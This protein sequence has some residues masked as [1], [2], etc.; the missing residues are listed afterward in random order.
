[1]T[2]LELHGIE[3][4]FGATAALDGVDLEVGRGEV[5]ALI[6]ENGA[7]KSTLMNVLSGTFPPDGGAMRL[8]GAPYSPSGPAEARR[9]GIAH[10]HQELSL[11]PHLSVAENILMG[12]EP[13]AFGWIRRDELFDRAARLLEEFGRDE[14]DPRSRTGDLPLPDRQIVEICRALAWN[15]RILLMDEPT[16]TLQRGNVERLFRLVRQ[17]R[18]RGIAVIYISH[19]LEEVRE[20]ADRYT[21]LRDGKSVASGDLQSV[22]D[23]DLISLMVGRPMEKALEASAAPREG[24]SEVLLE[25]QDL[26]APPRLRSASFQLHRGEVL[27]IAGLIG[28]GRTELIRAL[29]G[30]ARATAG[31]VR[32]RGEE[33]PLGRNRSSAQIR[34]GFGFLSEDR[35]G[36]GLALQISVADNVTIS[37]LSSCARGGWIDLRRQRR[38]AEEV[39][40]RLRIKAP[41]ARSP[42]LRLSGGNQQKVAL[43]RLLHQDPEI[44]LLDEPARGIDIA[45]KSDI[46]R[47]ITRLAAQGKAVLMVSSYLP[48]LLGVCDRIAVMSRG[49]LSPARPAAEWTPETIL[50]V[51]VG[52]VGEVA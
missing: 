40:G 49:R 26:A 39:M 50:Q 7:G 44:L 15:A 48:E 24:S 3:K 4:R 34:R 8:S 18:D 25:V 21:V 42:V 19:F 51:A 52:G 9:R 16:S 31:R 23:D 28:S 11:C 5:H 29:F 45:S 22:R 2:L 30:L 32:L 13:S 35:K 33:L 46:Y 1:V 14:I 37:R 27:G 6:G 47:E 17:L 41:G 20:I 12:S 36:E 10:I 38:Q 43:G